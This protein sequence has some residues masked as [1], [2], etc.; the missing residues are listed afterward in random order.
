[1]TD[2]QMF[3]KKKSKSVKDMLRRWNKGG[4]VKQQDVMREIGELWK[5]EKKKVRMNGG[6]TGER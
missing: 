3:V 1:M 6:G 4:K 5:M 2:Y